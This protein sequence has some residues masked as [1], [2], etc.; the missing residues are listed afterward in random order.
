MRLPQRSAIAS[1]APM[2]ACPPPVASDTSASAAGSMQ[3][4]E[5]AS[6]RR[7]VA[8]SKKPIESTSSPQ[9]SILTGSGYMGE[10]KSSMPPRRAYCPAPS[11]CAVF[12]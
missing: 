2:S 3:H 4:S 5:T 8:V 1:T 6:V 7:W 12:V 11:T 10:K 9:N